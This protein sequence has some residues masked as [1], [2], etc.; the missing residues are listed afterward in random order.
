MNLRS[1]RRGRK[2]LQGMA[3]LT[4]LV[5]CAPPLVQAQTTIAPAAAAMK[6]D[7]SITIQVPVRLANFDP[8]ATSY[9]PIECTVDSEQK[10]SA[11][12][13]V[14]LAGGSFNGTVDVRVDM[15]SS[16]NL[17]KASSFYCVLHSRSPRPQEGLPQDIA[18]FD[19][20]KPLNTSVA[21]AVPRSN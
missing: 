21:G 3:A 11:R 18:K 5:F 12:A 8:R 17:D 1:V 6:P 13:Y 4:S 19:K 15:G 16:R 10:R 7:W 9:L 2:T 20:S 14:P